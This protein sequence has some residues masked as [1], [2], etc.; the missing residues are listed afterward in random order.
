MLDREWAAPTAVDRARGAAKRAA[1][2]LVRWAW[3]GLVELGAIG[4]DITPRAAASVRSAP[5]A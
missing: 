5:A 2:E 4:P 3:D 1:G